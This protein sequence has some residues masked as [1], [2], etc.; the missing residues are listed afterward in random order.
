MTTTR[1]S[2]PRTQSRI[3]VLSPPVAQRTRLRTRATRRDSS[4]EDHEAG[5]EEIA[6]SP[7][8]PALYPLSAL[9]GSASNTRDSVSVPSASP[10]IRD[11]FGQDY[12]PSGE[13]SPGGASQA[14]TERAS[15]PV[16]VVSA[17]VD[18]RFTTFGSA[19]GSS[20]ERSSR[21]TAQEKGK[22]RVDVP[23]DSS[24]Q[25]WRR[26]DEG[27]IG[28]VPENAQ[29][30]DDNFFAS[31]MS[32]SPPLVTSA[33]PDAVRVPVAVPTERVEDD[34]VLA[35]LRKFYAARVA[36]FLESEEIDAVDRAEVQSQLN[37]LKAAIRK[38]DD[39]EESSKV[40]DWMEQSL[41]AM[42]GAVLIK[43]HQRLEAGRET[44]A[45]AR[46]VERQ[47]MQ[48]E[49]VHLTE[50]VE[51]METEQSN[52]RQRS[53]RELRDAEAALAALR[54]E[55]DEAR[56]SLRKATVERRR[57]PRE[58]EADEVHRQLLREVV[59]MESR[60]V[61]QHMREEDLADGGS[62]TT[63]DQ[64]LRLDRDGAIYQISKQ[65][66]YYVP[67]MFGIDPGRPMKV[68]VIGWGADRP[69]IPVERDDVDDGD[70]IAPRRPRRSGRGAPG[71]DDGDDDGS[72][73]D[74]NRP[75]GPARRPMPSGHAA[76][77]RP[78]VESTR[79]RNDEKLVAR[80]LST[81]RDKVGKALPLSKESKPVRLDPKM[82]KFAGSRDF[83]V[84]ESWVIDVAMY[85]QTSH[86]G[87]KERDTERVNL[88]LGLLEGDAERWYR[89]RVLSVNREQKIWSS[90]QIVV[91]LYNRFTRAITL[92]D[93]YYKFKDFK[94]CPG[95]TVEGFYDE[96][97]MVVD[98]L[99]IPPSEHEVKSKFMDNLP[100]KYTSEMI[101]KGCDVVVDSLD[102]L[103]A[104][105]IDEEIA[106]YSTKHYA[107][108]RKSL[109]TMSAVSDDVPQFR[110]LTQRIVRPLKD[111]VTVVSP[112]VGTERVA[113]KGVGGPS[114]TKDGSG[115]TKDIGDRPWA[116]GFKPR[117]D[118]GMLRLVVGI[119][120]YGGE[121]T[122]EDLV[123]ESDA[124]EYSGSFDPA[125][126]P[127]EILE[128]EAMRDVEELKDSPMMDTDSIDRFTTKDMSEVRDYTARAPTSA[129]HDWRH[130]GER[131]VLKHC[132][133]DTFVAARDV[134]S[135]LLDGI[136]LDAPPLPVLPR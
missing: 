77:G 104:A 43:Q 51:N 129:D 42:M 117:V 19:W 132:R 96:L 27:S 99:A 111:P 78:K 109:Q 53:V 116:A 124:E 81:W 103:L 7:A 34:P 37:I 24:S 110:L 60:I 32:P 63:A 56:E 49:I 45:Q 69:I 1:I 10:E 79:R 26:R 108:R 8:P 88:M 112:A 38:I 50:I 5:D 128:Y 115:G 135:I 131:P 44:A 48:S 121:T 122:F 71:D 119:T 85:F 97:K 126:D 80:L 86:L 98:L 33:F 36:R 23:G 87:G 75:G 114:N 9:H 57:A 29:E 6:R 17:A 68:R 83:H 18:T 94:W 92:H 67:T 106:A 120:E 74:G 95:H 102:Y 125:T 46:I 14:S 82:I 136:S 2:A 16:T 76:S 15:S 66:D 127:Y 25:S 54:A 118:V 12:A 39:S 13:K 73:K 90:E 65:G 123:I 20:A 93:N 130:F 72:D 58:E 89:S 55:Y 22:E 4:T 47:S 11:A 91:G 84:L 62:S 52:E 40:A 3:P 107:D 64:G 101:E 113:S 28:S 21:L 41:C 133:P 61:L 70:S 134:T 31:R 105:A 100:E 35:G 30:Y 59:A